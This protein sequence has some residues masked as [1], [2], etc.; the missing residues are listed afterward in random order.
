MRTYSSS[1]WNLLNKALQ[2]SFLSARNKLDNCRVGGVEP[3]RSVR[4]DGLDLA[5]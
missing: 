5:E 3:K 4:A 2:Y 1:S